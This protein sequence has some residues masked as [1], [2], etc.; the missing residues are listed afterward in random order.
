MQ[1]WVDFVVS[2]NTYAGMAKIVGETHTDDPTNSFHPLALARGVKEAGVHGLLIA[3][4]HDQL[5]APEGSVEL[6]EAAGWDLE[7]VEDA[8]HA[9][10]L[11]EPNKWRK[12]VLGFLDQR[13]S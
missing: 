8:G 5:A 11:E 6:A 2:T 13:Q 7:W 12:L 1:T 3:G 10:P 4:T 9:S